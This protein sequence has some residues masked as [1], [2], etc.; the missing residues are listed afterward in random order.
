MYPHDLFGLVVF[1]LLHCCHFLY[2]SHKD[3]QVDLYKMKENRF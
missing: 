2:N 3:D 1:D